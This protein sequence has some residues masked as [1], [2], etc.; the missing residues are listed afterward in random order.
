MIAEWSNTESDTWGELKMAVRDAPF[1]FRNGRA[2]PGGSSAL[3]TSSQ[4]FQEDKICAKGTHLCRPR[5]FGMDG[6]TPWISG[7]LPST[8]ISIHEGA[9]RKTVSR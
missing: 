4:E 7:Y 1:P 9:G 2:S 5:Y 8:N 6:M 3:F